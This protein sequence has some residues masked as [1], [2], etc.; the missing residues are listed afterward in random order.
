MCFLLC[1]VCVVCVCRFLILIIDTHVYRAYLSQTLCHT[2]LSQNMSGDSVFAQ[3]RSKFQRYDLKSERERERKRERER[4]RER[5]CH[6]KRVVARA[7]RYVSFLV[8]VFLSQEPTKQRL[9]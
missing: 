6:E 5:S 7:F 8:V 1:V 2:I 9:R 3:S 4:E